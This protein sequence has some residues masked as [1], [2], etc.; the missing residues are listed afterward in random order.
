MRNQD[1]IPLSVAATVAYFHLS[2]PHLL[3][4]PEEKM[5]ERLARAALA[6]SQLAPIHARRGD[7]SVADALDSREIDEKLF[8]P[9]RT[10]GLLDLD[11]F[12]IRRAELHA[13]IKALEGARRLSSGEA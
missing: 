11:A 5:S 13:A 7:G 4:Q 10:N 1:Y 8:R 12:V 6:L 3:A 2:D 9:M